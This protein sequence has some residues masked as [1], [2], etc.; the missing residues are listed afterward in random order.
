MKTVFKLSVILGLMTGGFVG[1]QSFEENVAFL[2]NGSIPVKGGF[3]KT[4]EAKSFG[5]AVQY[6][7]SLAMFLKDYTD[8]GK[9]NDK[10]AGDRIYTSVNIFKS[11]ADDKKVIG[12]NVFISQ[13]F[14]H[15]EE[16]QNYIETKNSTSKGKIK[17]TPTTVLNF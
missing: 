3:A 10:V 13:E 8:D 16:L 2:Y 4:I 9:N 6:E 7:S 15:S 11:D 1:A 5:E 17:M 14:M 12:N